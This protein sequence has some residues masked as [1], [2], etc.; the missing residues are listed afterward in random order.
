[1]KIIYVANNWKKKGKILKRSSDYGHHHKTYLKRYKNGWI[2]GKFRL[3]KT[4]P[5]MKK[6][7]IR[8]PV[9]PCW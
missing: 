6:A 1:M 4:Y 8:M 2:D 5:Q 9:T 3:R 7:A